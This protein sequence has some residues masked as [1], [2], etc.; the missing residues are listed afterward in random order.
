MKYF[1]RV[2]WSGILFAILTIITGSWTADA[3]K[4]EPL[5]T[6][7]FP[8]LSKHSVLTAV[9]SLLLFVISFLSLFKHRKDF[10]AIK[11]LSQNEC[12]PHEGLIITLSDQNPKDIFLPDYTF[13]LKISD[14]SGG[15][16]LTGVLESDIES[17]NAIRWNWQQLLR[18]LKPHKK[19]L[20]YVYLI[21]SKDTIQKDGSSK[22]GSFKFM[23][24]ATA[25]IKKY[26]PDIKV[27]DSDISSNTAID[28]EDINM[29]INRINDAVNTFKEQGLNEKNII[30]DVTGGPKPTSI[31]GAIVTLNSDVTFQYVQTNPDFKT[32]A[33]DVTVQSPVSF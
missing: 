22:D 8:S 25:L 9:G 27:F 21:G 17:L 13:P 29:L 16:F 26:F 33:Y 28:F 19:T 31:A 6:Q 12:A 10:L 30:I 15:K 3:L 5:F 32:L 23:K 1:R 18:G 2:P 11:G 20:K 7:W 14:I 4:G 24:H